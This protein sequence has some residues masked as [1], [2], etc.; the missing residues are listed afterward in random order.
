M[1][2]SEPF[3]EKIYLFNE[4]AESI[5][6]LYYPVTVSEYDAYEE[7]YRR[8]YESFVQGTEDFYFQVEEASVNLCLYLYDDNMGLNGGAVVEL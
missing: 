1:E 8:M 6:H 3:V 2:S 4:K 7:K 5:S